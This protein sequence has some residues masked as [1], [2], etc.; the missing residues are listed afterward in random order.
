MFHHHICQNPGS[1]CPG[2][3]T[4]PRSHG[5]EH[6]R[7]WA[8]DVAMCRLR[9]LKSTI[10]HHFPYEIILSNIQWPYFQTNPC[11]S[12]TF[13]GPTTK[14]NAWWWLREFFSKEP[15]VFIPMFVASH[16]PHYWDLPPKI[17]G[18]FVRNQKSKY[19]S[20]KSVLAFSTKK[21]KYLNPVVRRSPE[22]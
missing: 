16:R 15:G 21:Q 13:L 9:Y 3:R 18:L 22:R 10:D 5:C 2:W 19:I 1:M 6:A 20:W 4:N 12:L 8:I 17:L 7:A 11:F 14:S